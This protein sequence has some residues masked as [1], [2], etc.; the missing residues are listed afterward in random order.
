METKSAI[1]VI[2]AMIAAI[3]V[4]YTVGVSIA[5]L[6]AYHSY[7]SAYYVSRMSVPVHTH[8][9]ENTGETDQ[10]ATPVPTETPEE[11]AQ[12]N[13]ERLQA[14]EKIENEYKE[15][16]NKIPLWFTHE[17][18]SNCIPGAVVAGLFT[19]LIVMLIYKRNPKLMFIV[20]SVVIILMI[21]FALNYIQHPPM[22]L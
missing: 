12:R 20:S 21:Y 6:V 17:E 11:E 18:F 14:M 7:S 15:C 3:S 13:R 4:M 19:G 5:Y 9:N 8:N 10:M 22:T 2:V 16:V 1:A